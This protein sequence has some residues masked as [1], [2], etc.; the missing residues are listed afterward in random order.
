M[1]SRWEKVDS[2]ATVA[3]KFMRP[4]SLRSGRRINKSCRLTVRPAAPAQEKPCTSLMSQSARSAAGKWKWGSGELCWR[5]SKVLIIVD[6]WNHLLG[7]S[8]ATERPQSSSL[9]AADFKRFLRFSSL[10]YQLSQ[11]ILY[12]FSS[13]SGELKF[14]I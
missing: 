8:E 11:K 2:F 10:K 4:A 5:R 13:Y 3:A 6:H 1:T 14:K 7:K 12:L 9:T